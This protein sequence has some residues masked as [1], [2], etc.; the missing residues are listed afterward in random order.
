MTDKSWQASVYAAW[1]YGAVERHMSMETM[2]CNSASL[3]GSRI[4]EVRNTHVGE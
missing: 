4:K 1:T 2:R 3:N